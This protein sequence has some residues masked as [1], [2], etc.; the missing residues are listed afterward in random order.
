MEKREIECKV[1]KV[2][3]ESQS[4]NNTIRLQVVQWGKYKPVL[5]KREYYTDPDGNEKTGKAKG[6]NS[7][8]F[9]II[10]DNSEE[11]EKLLENS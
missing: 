8:D 6:L 4:R 9:S 10:L 2:F 11:I 7:E 1:L 3:N 5:E